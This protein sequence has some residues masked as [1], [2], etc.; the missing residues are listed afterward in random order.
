VS[1][2]VVR[3]GVLGLAAFGALFALLGVDTAV[4]VWLVRSAFDAPL[5]VGILIVYEGMRSSTVALAVVVAVVL[6][7]RGA[8]RPPA[9]L[10]SALLVL[11][12]IG[13]AK[14]TSYSGFPGILQER[15]ARA[16]LAQGTPFPVMAFVFG[17]PAWAFGLAAA[18]FLRLAVT[19][20]GEVTA[21]AVLAADA[22]GRPGMLRGHAVAGADVGALARRL[23][24]AA[25]GGRLLRPAPVWTAALLLALAHALAL[26]LVAAIASV[27]GIGLP[28]GLG[29]PALRAG[30]AAADDEDRARILWFVQA[31]VVA[32]L[33]LLMA[34]ILS[35]VPTSALAWVPFAVLA[36]APM[37]V[38]LCLATALAPAGGVD[39]AR[40]LRFTF[41][42][43]GAGV[44]GVI[45]GSL[46][47]TVLQSVLAPQ[48]ELRAALALLG[49]AAVVVPAAALLRARGARSWPFRTVAADR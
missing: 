12:A 29:I 18:A 47:E 41:L 10:A 43:G 4:R 19:F 9:V 42:W 27:L 25:L 46:L 16:L 44:A 17:Q 24:A 32:A 6:G 33:A 35:F 34:G 45:V 15:M 38:L 1:A 37:V 7:W 28:L 26:P 2:A 5:D 39:P 11:L 36:V 21:D 48:P 31:A 22:A 20:P 40:A 30:Y 23:S 3:A 49:A 14:A 13:Y 8:R